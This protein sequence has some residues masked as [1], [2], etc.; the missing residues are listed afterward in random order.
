M[1]STRR[2]TSAAKDII[3]EDNSH[4]SMTEMEEDEIT[5]NMLLSQMKKM[6]LELSSKIDIAKSPF[7][8]IRNI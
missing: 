1:V 8:F 2:N 6:E 5:L 7:A 4:D 3:N